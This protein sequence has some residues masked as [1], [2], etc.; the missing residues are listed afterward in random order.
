MAANCI[1]TGFRIKKG[2]KL[3]GWIKTPVKLIT[4]TDLG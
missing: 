2:D 3:K 4:V 1:K